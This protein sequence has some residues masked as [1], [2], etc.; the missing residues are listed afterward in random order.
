MITCKY[1]G[2]EIMRTREKTPWYHVD[3]NSYLCDIDE[4]TYN[5]VAEPKPSIIDEMA[6]KALS[7][8][9]KLL[10]VFS[11][12]PERAGSEL[13]LD[14]YAEHPMS[15]NVIAIEVKNDTP[16]GKQALKK[17]GYEEE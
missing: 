9:E 6:F 10:T 5:M 1:C 11:L 16:Q 2:R 12:L 13:V 8:K 14:A 15:L 17:L 4:L 7:S 3:T